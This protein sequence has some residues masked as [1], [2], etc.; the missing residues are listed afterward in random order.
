MKVLVVDDSRTM[1]KMLRQA[2][3]RME[4]GAVEV[5]EAGDGVQAIEILRGISFEVDLLLLDWNM[6]QLDGIGF[7]KQ[8][9]ALSPQREIPAIMVTSLAQRAQVAEAMRWG[10][11]DYLVKPFAMEVLYEK[12]RKAQ[13]RIE[14]S[15]CQETSVMLRNLAATSRIPEDAPFLDRLPADLADEFRR[16]A[17]RKAFEAGAILLRPEEPVEALH[18]IALGEVEI[19]SGEGP[20]DTEVRGEGDCFAE[21]PFMAQDVA[22][23]TVRARGKVEVLLLTRPQVSDLIRQDS[24]LG[25]FLSG[26]VTRRPG[27]GGPPEEGLS[28]PAALSGR[29]ETLPI[30]DL[31][32][33]LNIC[34]KTGHLRLDHEGRQAGLYFEEGEIRHAWA[35]PDSGEKAFFEVLEWKRATFAFESGARSGQATLA[36]PT[37][38]LL[39]EGMRLLDERRRSSEEVIP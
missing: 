29:L 23:C 19:V 3:E 5:V 28:A 14:S 17:A 36:S 33:I 11:R 1:R 30:P 38:T 7:L 37:M 35:G 21:L 16:R 24:R 10:I 8:L 26:L 13:A 27:K 31:V 9:K 12:V 25:Y 22:R 34:R 4:G 6:P 2:L 32:Q 20:G 15:R 18:L 39:M